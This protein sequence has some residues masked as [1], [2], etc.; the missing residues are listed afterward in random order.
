MAESPK[1]GA[2]WDVVAEVVA[3][4]QTLATCVCAA[5]RNAPMSGPLA[6]LRTNGR[7]G[8]GLCFP[9]PTAGDG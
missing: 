7:V 2:V 3:H 4:D 6:P 9:F 1:M 8:G 5:S